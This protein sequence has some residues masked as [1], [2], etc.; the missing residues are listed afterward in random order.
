LYSFAQ[1]DRVIGQVP[2][3]VVT[4]LRQVDI[5]QGTEALYRDQ[6]PGLLESLSDRARVASITASSAIE[7]V[8]VADPARERAIV[9]GRPSSLRTRS[10]Q[11]LAGYRDALDYLFQRDWRPLNV[12][13]LLHLHRLLF[14]YTP[15][16][17]GH[18]KATDRS[19]AGL[20]PRM[21]RGG[22]GPVAVVDISGWHPGHGL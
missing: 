6:L 18:F 10:E 5:G 15:A 1:L 12:G 4:T 11:E 9:E 3:A 8:V 17:G 2:A 21:A 22:G 7:G 13:L 14:S 19:A 20:D 16:G